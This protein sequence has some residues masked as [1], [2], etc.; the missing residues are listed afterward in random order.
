MRKTKQEAEKTY[1]SLLEA[2]A[3][4]F[5]QKGVSRTTLQDIA[6]QANMTKGAVYWHFK[7]KE[8]II[9]ALMETYAIPRLQQFDKNVDNLPK[10]QNI[11]KHFR[12]LLQNS[13]LGAVGDK[14]AAQALAITI[15]MVEYTNVESEFQD[16]MQHLQRKRLEALTK[17]C[18]LLRDQSCLRDDLAPEQAARGLL[19]YILGL[20]QQHYSRQ[21]LVDL[22][23]DGPALLDIYLDAIILDR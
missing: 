22:S 11:G 9:R 3:D 12:L 16:F 4:L 6:A 17:A 5:L 1:T 21:P 7:G 8:D 14:R 13:L 18:K 15:H 20:M 19:C 23:Q 2:A 10:D